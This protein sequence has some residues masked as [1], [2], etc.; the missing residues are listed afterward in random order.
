MPH[1]NPQEPLEPLPSMLD[2]IIAE[3]VREYLAGQRWDRD[4]GG[5][6]LED[7]AEIFKVGVS[8]ANDG[9][10][11]AEGGDVGACM[12]FVGSVHRAW[13]GAVGL[14]VLDLER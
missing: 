13:G 7:V 8:A 5:L 4:T 6:A 2:H 10:A 9:V 1:D 11:Q 3:A 14:W 12:D